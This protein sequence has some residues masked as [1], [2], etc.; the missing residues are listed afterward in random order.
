MRIFFQRGACIF[1]RKKKSISTKGILSFCFF[2]IFASLGAW[3]MQKKRKILEQWQQQKNILLLVFLAISVVFFFSGFQQEMLQASSTNY[4]EFDQGGI[5]DPHYNKVFESNDE[6]IKPQDG[7]TVQELDR[8]FYKNIIPII[9]YIF[10]FVSMLYWA[11]YSVGFIVS[12]G[13]EEEITANRKNLLFGL[14]GFVFISLAIQ[15]GDIFSPL[16]RG[17]ELIDQEGA[18]EE[19]RKI[20]A[21]LQLALTSISIAMLF[22][23]AVKFITARGED[24]QIDSAKKIFLW[25]LVGLVITMLAVPLVENIFY[26]APNSQ[27]GN[28]EIGNFSSEFAG[29]LKF[30]L[31]FLAVLA[32]VSFIIS[33]IYFITSF[34]NEEQQGKAKT[35][36]WASILGIIIILTSYTIIRTFVPST[37]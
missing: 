11:L 12:R 6:L 1:Q 25:S 28:E 5:L 14:L 19:V 7:S 10:L 31:M 27:L 16:G 9:K 29:F 8:L 4:F 20:T 32:F 17:A 22:Y 15:L 26:P 21:Y 34:G 18:K 35:I 33:G 23:A 3:N 2:G 36:L 24:D 13:N 30:A 37:G